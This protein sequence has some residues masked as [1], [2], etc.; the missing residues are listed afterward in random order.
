MTHKI[1]VGI[2]VYHAGAEL[3]RRLEL[4]SVNGFEVYVFD[5]SPHIAN[6]REFSECHPHIHYFTC[7]KNLGLGVGIS[8][9][10]ANAYQQGHS[11]LLFFD[12]DTGFSAETLT[13]V[14]HNYID[15]IDSY[16]TFSAIAFKADGAA[17]VR[18]VP[19]VINSG[20]LYFLD[21]LKTIDWM[22][23]SYFVDGV[24]YKLCLDSLNKGYRIG[25][26]GATPGFD[27][28]TEQ[29]D[30]VYRIAGHSY[31]MRA[32][33]WSRIK[34]AVSSNLK[35][36]FCAIKSHQLGFALKITRLLTLYC[37]SQILVRIINTLGIYK[38]D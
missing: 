2:V 19:L 3:L 22:D 29:A 17:S 37:T 32:Y 35:L 33:S 27:H 26:C 9:V 12:Q 21:K 13:Y 16:S 11:A 20:S 7:G 24:D 8:T 25:V 36:I 1:A 23:C 34:D 6:V 28:V 31:S 15:N 4:T 38:R 30:S 14:E 18:D 10:C 5:N